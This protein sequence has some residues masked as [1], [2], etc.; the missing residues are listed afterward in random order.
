MR[1]VGGGGSALWAV[2]IFLAGAETGEADTEVGQEVVA[3]IQFD[4]RGHR[5]EEGMWDAS[6]RKGILPD[7]AGP[8]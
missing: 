8:K 6:R 4:P 5:E 2:G 1:G 3:I 7:R